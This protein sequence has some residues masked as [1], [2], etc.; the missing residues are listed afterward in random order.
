[1]VAVENEAEIEADGQP[2]KMNVGEEKEFD[3][4]RRGANSDGGRD[5]PAAW[6]GGLGDGLTGSGRRW[7]ACPIKLGKKQPRPL[8][9]T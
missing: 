8:V 9:P 5:F 3:S 6:C 4:V 2:V 1:M 7:R